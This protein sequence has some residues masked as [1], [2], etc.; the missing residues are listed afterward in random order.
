MYILLCPTIMKRKQFQNCLF[1]NPTSSRQATPD[2][3]LPGALATLAHIDF[4]FGTIILAAG[5]SS[6]MGQPKLLLPWRDTSILKHLLS[7]WQG[8]GSAQI[9]VVHAGEPD[10]LAELDRWKFSSDQ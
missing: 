5:R 9:V 2:Y 6:R 8:V 10:L 3:S 7:Q 1:E 4:A